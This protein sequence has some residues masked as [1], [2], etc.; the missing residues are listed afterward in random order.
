VAFQNPRSPEDA[1]RILRE[2]R[3]QVSLREKGTQIRVAPA[4]FNNAEEIDAF[5]KVAEKLAS[6]EA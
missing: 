3:V 4:L 2:A 1:A 5:L 6:P